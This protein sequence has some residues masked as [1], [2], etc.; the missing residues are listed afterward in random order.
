M[1]TFKSISIGVLAVSLASCGG[2]LTANQQSLLDQVQQGA[3]TA[4]GFMPT[5][6]TVLG[7]LVPG[8][9][10]VS[11]AISAICAAVAPSPAPPGVAAAPRRLG[12]TL[13]VTTPQGKTV[14]GMF[15]R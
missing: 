7:L 10:G 3:V 11:A 8:A 6:A 9:S 4:C 1:R 5:A 13:Q 12:Q 2:S 14:D 15:V